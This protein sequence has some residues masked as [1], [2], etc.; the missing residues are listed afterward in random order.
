MATALSW[1]TKRIRRTIPALESDLMRPQLPEVYK[2]VRIKGHSP[3]RVGIDP[4]HPATHLR[5]KL[6]IPATVERIGEVDTPSVAAHLHHLGP[7]LH[8]TSFG[9]GHRI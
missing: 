9:M 8:R 4:H 6:V 2:E 5:V 3:A 1:I 7:A